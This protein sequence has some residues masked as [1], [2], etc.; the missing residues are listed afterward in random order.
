STL[1][2]VAEAAEVRDD[3]PATC[4]SYLARVLTGLPQLTSILVLDKDG[5]PRCYSSAPLPDINLGDRYY[6]RE[7]KA[8]KQFAVGDYVVSRATGLHIL[9]V[10]LPDAHGDDIDFIVTAGLNLEWLGRQ[11]LDRGMSR[12]GIVTIADRNGIIVAREPTPEQFIGTSFPVGQMDLLSSGPGTTEIVEPDGVERIIGF[13]PSPITPFGLFVSTGISKEEALSATDRSFRFSIMLFV[14][15][16]IAAFLLTWLVGNTIIRRPLI[17]MVVTAESWRRGQGDARTGLSGRKDEIGILGQT[18]DRLMDEN[19]QREQERELAE[20]RREI[21]VHELAHRVKNTLATV[22]SIASLSFRNSQGPEAL[23]NFH[24][25]LH[26]LV[27]S[28][29]LLTRRN[30][31]RADLLEVIEAALAPAREDRAHRF[32]LTGPLVGLR[33]ASVV[34]IAM[35]FHELCTNS[36]KYGALSNDKGRVT[37]QWSARDEDNGTAVSLIWSETDGPAVSQPQREGFGT[38]LIANL[39]KQLNGSA[40]M[41]YPPSGFVCN[42]RFVTPHDV[43]KTDE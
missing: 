12:G 34:P 2:A 11:L 27:R 3:N 40:D 16:C 24:D 20:T 15:G 29:D 35:I 9:P 6:I 5:K 30:W 23:R 39:T 14:L 10:A 31:E 22:Q 26:A 18:F 8:T 25:R 38:R 42:I 28:H 4:G 1:H 7:A 13:V 43:E 21:L 32:T 19:I 36:L 33:S 41:R 17:Q 37:V